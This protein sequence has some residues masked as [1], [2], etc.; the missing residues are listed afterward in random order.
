ML[1]ISAYTFC[2]SHYGRAY[3]LVG[4]RML[5]GYLQTTDDLCCS[6]S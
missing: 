6:E 2:F 1:V 5:K 4:G 3:K